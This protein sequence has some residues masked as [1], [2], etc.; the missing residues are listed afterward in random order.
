MLRTTGPTKPTTR[1]ALL[2]TG[3]AMLLAG[4]GAQVTGSA[5]GSASGTSAGTGSSA[6]AT[7]TTTKAPSGT[8]AKRAEKVA[9][10]LRSD[11]TLAAYQEKLIILEPRVSWPGFTDDLA[12]EAALSGRG[13]LAVDAPVPP[14]PIQVVLADGTTKDLPVLGAKAAAGEALT[15]PC[16]P[17]ERCTLSFD[18]AK[19]SSEQVAT[20]KGVLD[21]PVWRF[22]GG[23]M[24][25]AATVIA[26]DPAGLGSAPTA[27]DTGLG[28][29]ADIRAAT[30]LYA[31]SDTAVKYA[32]GVGS[33]DT[34]ITP[35]VYE[36]ADIVVIGATVTPPSGACDAA[37]H[38][39]PV[40]VTLASP[41]GARPLVD[42]SSGMILAP[43]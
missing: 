25:G 39:K 42:V 15:N 5:A 38:L 19:L 18:S 14:S 4:C 2:V 13:A 21:L 28:Y 3:A 10:G 20:N 30:A 26:V 11:G 41:L 27:P 22:T 31:V 43:R 33:C 32:V 17:A 36:A 9:A 40:E 29:E 16:G 35:S 24:T 12:K 34:D 8:F 7:T 23:G 37:M 1:R 6:S